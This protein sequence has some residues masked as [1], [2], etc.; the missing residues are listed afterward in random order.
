MQNDLRQLLTQIDIL[1]GSV[2]D[3]YANIPGGGLEGYTQKYEQEL[4]NH[5]SEWRRKFEEE[6]KQNF[7]KMNMFYDK[8]IDVLKRKFFASS[9]G[10]AELA[11]YVKEMKVHSDRLKQDLRA[12]DQLLRTF[13]NRMSVE[14][15]FLLC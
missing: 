15:N 12:S 13:Q 6:T 10:N 3:V 9:K 2:S 7:E 8:S 5:E 4:R 14:Q 11:K 1:N